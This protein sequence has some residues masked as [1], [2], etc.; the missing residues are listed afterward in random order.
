MSFGTMAERCR[1]GKNIGWEKGSSSSSREG[2]TRTQRK[3][4]ASHR[5]WTKQWEK[6]KRK[7]GSENEKGEKKKSWEQQKKE[8]EKRV[9]ENRE[10]G[11]VHKLKKGPG[12]Y[13]PSGCRV[14]N[15]FK[16]KP[17]WSLGNGGRDY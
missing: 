9:G 6:G 15:G 2:N 4:G 13:T 16:K 10:R 7:E 12:R 11:S 1:E 3:E 14:K 17:E 5:L 8:R